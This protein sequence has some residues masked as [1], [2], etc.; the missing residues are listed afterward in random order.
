MGV[1]KD[2]FYVFGESFK[3]CMDNMDMVLTRCEE[4][5][6]VLNWEKCDFMVKEGIILGHKISRRGLEV[7]QVKVEVIEK[8]L[9]SINIKEI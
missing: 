4:R 2:G 3:R 7:D 6:L 8:L 9:P 1:F 5:N